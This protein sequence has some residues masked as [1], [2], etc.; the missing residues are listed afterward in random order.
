M[1]ERG[2]QRKWHPS[3]CPSRRIDPVFCGR[4]QERRGF[5]LL[6][7]DKLASVRSP[8]ELVGIIVLTFVLIFVSY[9]VGDYLGGASG[10]VGVLVGGMIGRAAGHGREV[11]ATP[12][13]LEVIPRAAVAEG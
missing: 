13:G 6:Y 10:L 12:L 7:P 8:A 9:P 11:R 3:N 1:T 5:V 4:G 2:K